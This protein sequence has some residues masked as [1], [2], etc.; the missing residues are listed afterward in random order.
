MELAILLYPHVNAGTLLLIKYYLR[1]NLKKKNLKLSFSKKSFLEQWV[2]GCVTIPIFILQG[3]IC[4]AQS[5]KNIRFNHFSADKG[6]SQPIFSSIIQDQK[7]YMWFGTF[8]GLIKY[9]GYNITTFNSDPTNKNSLP[10]DGVNKLCEDSNGNIWIASVNYPRLTKYDPHTGKFTV[11]NGDK[12]RNQLGLTG[13]VYSL[14]NDKQG[15]L[16]VGTD[17]GLCFYDPV[18]DIFT[19]LS[20][21]IFPDTL[22]N[23]KV[24]SLMVDHSGQLW[25]GTSNGINIYDP[26]RQKMH[27]FDLSAKDPT[28]SG[29]PVSCM[30][31]DHS[32]NI[33]IALLLYDKGDS[34][35]CK[36]NPET[37]DLKI[38][39]HSTADPQSLGAGV[40]NTLFEDRFHNIWVGMYEGGMSICQAG[41]DNFINYK[42]D[43]TDPYALGSNNVIDLFEDRSGMMW[44]ATNGG[45]LN[46]CIAANVKFSIYQNY[47]KEFRS[48][49]PLSLY[50]DRAGRIFITTFGAGICEFNPATGNFK[51]YKLNTPGN[52]LDFFNFNFGMTEATD[53]NLW[54]VSFSEGLYQLDRKTGK[55]ITIH[56]PGTS[57]NNDAGANCITE[58]LDQRLWIGTNNGLKCYNPKTKTYS[59]FEDI[60]HGPDQL[61]KDLI[62]S[63]YAD[64]KGVLWIAG[65]NGLY[66]FNTKSGEVKVFKHDDANPRSL[67][68]NKP[69]S[70]YDGGSAKMWIGTEGGG[71]NE[72][73]KKTEQ[74][75]TYSVKDGLPGNIVYGILN[76]DQ[77][78]LWLSTNK[79][80]CRFTPPTPKNDKPVCRNYNMKDGL[81]S[82]ECFYNTSVKGDDGTLYF[83]TMAGLVSFK[84]SEIKDNSFIP[85]VVITAFSVLNKPV[86]PGDS[87]GILK[88]PID[89]TK[90]IKLSYRHNDISFTFAALNYV[91]PE[92]N[93]YAYKLEGY[94]KEWVYTDA[95][96]RFANYTNLDAGQYT[97]RIKAS[98]NDGVWNET[99]AE[100]QLMIKPPYWQTWWFKM[101]CVVIA[102]MILFAI[103]YSRMQKLRDIHRIRNKIASDLHDDLGATLSSISIMSELVN[104]QV[105]DRSPEASSL[106]EKIGSSSRNM[107]ESVNDMVW[108]I[109]PLNDSFENIIKR[110]RTFASEI[111]GAKDIAFHFD[112]DKNILQSKLKMEMRRNLYLIF[113]EAVNNAAKYS[114][115]ANAFVMI[116]NRE[117]NLKMTIRDDGS[118]FEMNTV[119]SGNGLLNMQ[120]RAVLMKARFNLESIPGKGTLVELEFK[121]M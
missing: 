107:I 17:A 27:F 77:G 71:L 93:Q 66:L 43:A 8:T 5:V 60:Y 72:F 84:P 29:K 64:S 34:Q 62:V 49:Y 18:S 69:I 65:T 35:I 86:S 31:E 73:D 44:I 80:L 94:D 63:L 96:K 110:M 50:K 54:A 52:N 58:D 36:Y 83:G 45:G 9:D 4:T 1:L 47:D 2:T 19:N 103:F 116:W 89:E 90:K 51:Q 30:L 101:L 39:Y 28:L 81:P 98:N 21:I 48:R 3:F 59:G 57:G 112:F 120:Q 56:T 95:A 22:S 41:Q 26:V 88:S 25:I 16:W 70:F 33:W 113:K 67:S 55:I 108:A 117:N 68:H 91:L 104:Q 105:K 106:L 24:S 12:E 37:G 115:A 23:Q 97:F 42:T 121:N 14:V 53:G 85:P 119:K 75:Y 32:G 61:S 87:T 7:G 100:I 6:I 46:N 11:Y 118:G 78:N 40:I 111:F 102:V 20:K 76:D 13:F 38:Y 99:A 114:Q 109:N 79:G 10:D 15:R 92:K 82:N 74:F